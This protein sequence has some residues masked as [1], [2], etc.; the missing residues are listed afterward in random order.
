MDSWYIWHISIS[1][2]KDFHDTSVPLALEENGPYLWMLKCSSPWEF[3]LVTF[4]RVHL[5]QLAT[6]LSSYRILFLFVQE[7]SSKLNFK[8][9]SLRF[10]L[11]LQKMNFCVSHETYLSNKTITNIPYKFGENSSYHLQFNVIYIKRE[12]TLDNGNLEN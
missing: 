7:R 9:L 4:E 11:E 12:A 3:S 10:F 6:L 8:W 5:F 2:Y 1:T